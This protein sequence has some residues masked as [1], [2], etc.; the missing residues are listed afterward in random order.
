MQA[1]SSSGL[2]G[3]AADALEAGSKAG[4]AAGQAV[5]A[6]GESMFDAL[7]AWRLELARAQ[8]VP[9]YVVFHDATLHAIADR[10]PGSLA[11]LAQVPGVGPTRLE[12]HGSDLVELVG[13]THDHRAV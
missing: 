5:L 13:E 12:R 1:D 4:L 3:A 6:A 10:R 11:D 9:P 8:R 7:R 2:G